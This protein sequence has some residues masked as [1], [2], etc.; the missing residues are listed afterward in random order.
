MNWSKHAPG[1]PTSL[2]EPHTESWGP[3]P[4]AWHSTTSPTVPPAS[5]P[6]TTRCT[7]RRTT[8]RHSCWDRT[9]CSL[10]LTV[11]S[12]KLLQADKMA[13]QHQHSPAME[14][15]GPY[16]HSM[17]HRACRTCGGNAAL[18]RGLPSL[19]RSGFSLTITTTKRAHCS[20]LQP[21]SHLS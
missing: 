18:P 21:S 20:R 14:D 2:G 7:R 9:V 16:L 3:T 12:N 13:Q 10:S 6:R 8:G 11:S 17:S 19:P 5:P 4:T 15:L 1:S